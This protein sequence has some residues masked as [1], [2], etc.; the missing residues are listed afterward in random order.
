VWPAAILLSNS[1]LRNQESAYV[2][3][4]VRDGT[5]PLT[6]AAA[7]IREKIYTIDILSAADCS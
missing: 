3:Q 2:N 6:I 7:G 4:A 1:T 5:T